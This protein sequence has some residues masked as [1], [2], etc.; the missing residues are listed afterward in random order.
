MITADYKA[1]ANSIEEYIQKTI[2]SL[3]GV[4]EGLATN[5]A[6]KAITETPLGNE[7]LHKRLY[8]QRI[9][10]SKWQSYGLSPIEGF[11]QGAW[12][13]SIGKS[14][15]SWS[16]TYNG[17]DA[18]QYIQQELKSYRIGDDVYITNIGPYIGNLENGSSLQAPQ[19]IKKPTLAALSDLYALSLQNYY[20]EVR[21]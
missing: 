15:T 18:F 12:Q 10:N 4:V 1:C 8:Q 3:S 17:E 21:N 7:E 6:Y 2:V 9:T 16:S 20:K 14:A 13:A 11:A 19:G 5:L